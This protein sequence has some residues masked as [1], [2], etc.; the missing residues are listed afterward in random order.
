VRIVAKKKDCGCGCV[1]PGKAVKAKRGK[2]PEA[3]GKAKKAA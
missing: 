3:K 2:R 1:P